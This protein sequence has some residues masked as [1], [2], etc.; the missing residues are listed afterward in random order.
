MV[1]PFS[2]RVLGVVANQQ[3]VRY[4]SQRGSKWKDNPSCP[5]ESIEQPYTHLGTHPNVV[6][7]LWNTFAAELPVQC[8]WVV[9]GTPV[10]V[11]PQSAIIFASGMGTVY[12][13]RLPP[14]VR[15]RALELGLAKTHRFSDGSVL[16][17]TNFGEEWVFGRALNE[18]RAWC[19]SAFEYSGSQPSA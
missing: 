12:A 13:L 9:Y 7:R 6:T 15:Y 1:T 14:D 2:I 10:L 19:L 16:D 11:N 5:P 3:L 18:E 8:N 17:L 4:L